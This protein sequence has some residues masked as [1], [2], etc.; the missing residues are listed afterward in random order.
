M[1]KSRKVRRWLWR[2]L[3]LLLVGAIVAG[4]LIWR[5]RTKGATTESFVTAPVELGSLRETVTATG[6]LSPLDAVEVGAEVTGR[7]LKVHV[8]VNDQVKVGQVLVEIDQ[9]Q[10]NARVEE[11][12]AQLSAASSSARNARASVKEAELKAQ[13]IRE[14]NKRGLASAQE[15]ETAEATLERAKAS[16]GSASAQ[17]TVARAGLKSAKTSQGKAV[18]KSPIDGI[19]LA[20]SVEPGQTVTSGFQTPVL[21]TLARDI[22][23]MQLKVDVDEADVGKVKDGQPATFVVD[24]HP[25]RQ[26][27]SKVVRLNNL[28]KAGTTVITYEGLLTVDNS[29]RLLRPGMTATAT[30]VTQQVKDALTVP[31][32]ALRFR[33]KSAAAGGTSRGA[34]LPVPGL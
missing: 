12:Q 2:V 18:I 8:D 4:V 32:A 6:T 24:A 9:E 30:I 27:R 14:L 13:R 34:A 23:Q 25:K 7:V 31:N 5:A 16:V 22:T 17:V 20:R 33:P 1:G 26:F 15:L 29:E 28:P 10:L 3:A 11:S 19:V 21:F